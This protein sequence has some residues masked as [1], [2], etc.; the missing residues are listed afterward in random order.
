MEITTNIVYTISTDLIS[1]QKL[2]VA[3]FTVY[4]S[5]LM[6]CAWSNSLIILSAV[7]FLLQY[8]LVIY[9]TKYV[10]TAYQYCTC[11]IPTDKQSFVAVT[12]TEEEHSIKKRKVKLPLASLSA[13]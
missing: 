1:I 6:I 13:E 3:N 5:I 4:S 2:S 9:G 10:K 8:S 11:T 12:S 7:H